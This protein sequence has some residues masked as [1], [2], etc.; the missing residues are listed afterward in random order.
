MKKLPALLFLFLSASIAN[1]QQ[2][3]KTERCGTDTI[4]VKHHD[5]YGDMIDYLAFQCSQ[6]GPLGIR[7]EWGLG[8]A[9]YRGTTQQWLGTHASMPLG[10]AFSYKNINLGVRGKPS[11]ME[12][13]SDIVIDG[14]LLE[15]EMRVNPSKVDVYAGYTF[16]LGWNFSVEPYAGVTFHK[17]EVYDEEKFNKHFSLPN[18]TGLHAGATLNKYF[19]LR[20]VHF[21]GLFAGYSYGLVNYEKIHPSLESNYSEWMAGITF[22]AIEK[23]KYYKK[24]R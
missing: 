20:D 13:R 11:L 1:A 12:P 10:L 9:T 4:H 5:R 7:V 15:K 24:I 21:L 14:Q 22:K 6:A 2:Y 3:D 19:R 23:R 8:S 18:H 16:N 17:W